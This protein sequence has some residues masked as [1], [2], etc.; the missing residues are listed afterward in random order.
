MIP[1]SLSKNG[2]ILSSGKVI[3]ASN[4]HDANTD[5]ILELA[6]M[7]VSAYDHLRL[8]TGL[9]QF[10]NV[11]STH[12]TQTENMLNE[13]KE[14]L[15]VDLINGDVKKMTIGKAFTE[16]YE[17]ERGHRSRYELWLAVKKNKVLL[18][19]TGSIMVISIVYYFKQIWVLTVLV[20]FLWALIKDIIKK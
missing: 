7:S 13:I 17:R 8:R 16:M 2:Y 6:A 9:H 15:T 5:D 10:E 4:F 14:M 3:D 18:I 19:S 20:P 12:I 1:S 11:I